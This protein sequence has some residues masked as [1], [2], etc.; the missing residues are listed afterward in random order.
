MVGHYDQLLYSD[1]ELCCLICNLS[2]IYFIVNRF[3]LLDFLFMVYYKHFKF[4]ELEIRIC[5][6][7]QGLIKI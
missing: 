3:I 5:G 7:L 6:I 1:D 2:I 4:K